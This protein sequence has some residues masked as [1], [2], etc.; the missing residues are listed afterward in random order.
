MH[1]KDSNAINR[2]IVYMVPFIWRPYENFNP[3]TFKL[4]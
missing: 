2:N 1:S 3:Q 4:N